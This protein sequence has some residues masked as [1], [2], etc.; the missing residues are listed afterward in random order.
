MK[1]IILANQE[2]EKLLT[3]LE[4]ELNKD[5]SIDSL[6]QKIE[7]NF[8]DDRHIYPILT[9]YPYEN[10]DDLMK[11]IYKDKPMIY[12][13]FNLE[14][15]KENFD[16]KVEKANLF[17]D[18]E[19]LRISDFLQETL[20]RGF[21]QL[22]LN[23]KI[24]S[25]VIIMPILLEMQAINNDSFS[26]FS[27]VALNADESK[28]L[29]GVC[30][31]VL[32]QATEIETIEYPLFSII[33]AKYNVIEGAYGQCI[34]QMLG[35][36]LLNQQKKHPLRVIYGCIT[37]GNVWK[38]MKLENNQVWIDR[39]QYFMDG[40]NFSQLGKILGIL[41]TIINSTQIKIL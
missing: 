36:Q 35:C 31:F 27:G 15:V 19:E 24:R 10:L 39:P 34:A 30:D 9:D 16:I 2:A 23:E 6:I 8:D 14:K 28:G 20:K 17:T 41:Q 3:I 18:V 40:S 38:F 11:S 1:T 4:K 33:E 29:K 7:G 25:E 12:S 26:I 22:L 37:T 21:K 13:E 32:S 5:E